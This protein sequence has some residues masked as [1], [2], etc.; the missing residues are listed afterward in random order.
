[1][2]HHLRIMHDACDL[3][4]GYLRDQTEL[5]QPPFDFFHIRDLVAQR[6]NQHVFHCV[7]ILGDPERRLLGYVEYFGLYR[8]V[9]V[10]STQYD[11]MPINYTLALDPATGTQLDLELK[12]DITLEEVAG[13]VAGRLLPDESWKTIGDYALPII[14]KRGQD[15]ELQRMIDDAI[16]EAAERGSFEKGSPAFMR[17]V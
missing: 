14:T 15:R 3:A 11:G 8:V 12:L 6:P 7:G 17:S 2:T 13:I 16:V 10:L 4:V 9:V 1:M 5:G